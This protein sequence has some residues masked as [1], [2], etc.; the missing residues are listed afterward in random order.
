MKNR[1]ATVSMLTLTAIPITLICWDA[2]HKQEELTGP[3]MVSGVPVVDRAPQ[4]QKAREI[5]LVH[6]SHTAPTVTSALQATDIAGLTKRLDQQVHIQGS[7]IDI[8]VLFSGKK[9]ILNFSPKVNGAV[10]AVVPE[11]SYGEF[12]DL[13]L[14]QG[15]KVLVSGVLTT[16]VNK[17]G[18]S[19]LQVDVTQQEQIKII[20]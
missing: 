16:F 7:V 14:L 1:F 11:E 17:K 3:P 18:K 20:D 6:V 10:N 9:T 8:F 19:L 15:K 13:R 2:V 4:A 12:S 5:D